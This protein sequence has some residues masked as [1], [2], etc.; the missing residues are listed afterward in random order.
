MDRTFHLRGKN[1][2]VVG[3]TRGIGRAIALE[4][5]RAGAGV[6]IAGRTEETLRSVKEELTSI[7]VTSVA[8]Q[9][10]AATIHGRRTLHREVVERFGV[11]HC[12][13]N[14]VGNPSAADLGPLLAAQESSWDRVMAIGA[15][16]AL[17]TSKE[18]VPVLAV[19]GAI[20]NISSAAGAGPNPNAGLY[21]AAKAA[22]NNLTAT[23]AT[24]WGH[25]GIRVNAIAPA[26]LVPADRPL[27]PSE[28]ARWQQRDWLTPLSRRGLVDDVARLCVFLA[29]DAASWLSAQ[30][31]HV[32]GGAPVGS[33]IVTFLRESYREH[34]DQ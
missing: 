16:T 14:N 26:A 9:C 33:P 27:D 19:G 17:F 4:M 34:L 13:V 5:A 18:F 20:L 22:L 1:V 30:V 28:E 15:K 21:A 10:N 8:V 24:E 32:D 12:L 7:G 25:L 6:A 2:V 11:I 29:S 3:G 31:F 23:M